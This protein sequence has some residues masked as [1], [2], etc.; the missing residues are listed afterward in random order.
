MLYIMLPTEK[1]AMAAGGAPEDWSD[2]F[3]TEICAVFEDEWG[4]TRVDDLT[5]INQARFSGWK[6]FTDKAKVRFECRHCDNNWTSIRGLVI[7]HYRLQQQGLKKVGE[8]RMYLPGQT[9]KPC[10]HLQTFEPP[11][12]Y[13]DEMVKVMQN[14]QKKIFEKFYSVESLPRKLNEG[15]RRANMKSNHE[16]QLCEAC[17]KGI[18]RQMVRD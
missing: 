3:E 11:E 18:C 13:R 15:Q 1:E 17:Q 9:C 14:L 8:V 7:F 6:Q 12:W 2:I 5:D 10:Q 16:S 4:L